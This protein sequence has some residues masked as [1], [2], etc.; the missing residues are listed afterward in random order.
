MG[1]GNE[2]KNGNCCSG[3]IYYNEGGRGTYVC[4]CFMCA[5]VCVCVR[6]YK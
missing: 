3:E 4:V 5:N 6:A 1:S 2:G